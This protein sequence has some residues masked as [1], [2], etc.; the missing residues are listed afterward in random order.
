VE[1]VKT[2]LHRAALPEKARRAM[3]LSRISGGNMPRIQGVPFI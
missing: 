2:K 1:V 3:F